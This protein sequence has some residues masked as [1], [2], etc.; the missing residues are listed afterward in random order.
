[1]AGTAPGIWQTWDLAPG[2][3]PPGGELRVGEHVFTGTIEGLGSGT[4]T[5]TDEWLTVD[6]IA[7]GKAA[8]TG[9]TGDFEGAYGSVVLEPVPAAP[10]DSSAGTYSWDITVP[11][12]GSLVTVTATGTAPVSIARNS[13]TDGTWTGT[14]GFSGSI[15]GLAPARGSGQSWWNGG[16][17]TFG[18]SRWEFTGTI[19]GLGTGT[20]TFDRIGFFP[21]PD[22]TWTWFDVVVD[23]TDELEGITGT[24]QVAAD[25]SYTYTLT[26]PVNQ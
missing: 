17:F 10:G 19:D 25:E 4:L 18:T 20:V 5:Y 13:D 14:G 7:S 12:K 22:G 24:G 26:A 2:G 1:M 9:G 11:P 21:I 8:I 6:G 3:G 23:G 16:D 15:V